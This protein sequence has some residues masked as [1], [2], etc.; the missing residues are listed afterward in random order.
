MH[1]VVN[2]LFALLDW[3][4]LHD[5]RKAVVRTIL[6]L[7]KRYNI[8]I[9]QHVLCT[10]LKY[11]NHVHVF[12]NTVNLYV[13]GANQSII[14][15]KRFYS[16]YNVAV[17]FEIPC[18][19]EQSVTIIN[20]LNKIKMKHSRTRRTTRKTLSVVF[21]LFYS[22]EKK[23]TECLLH[24]THRTCILNEL[25]LIIFFTLSKILNH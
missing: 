24:W 23:R 21:F 15:S 10:D 7:A 6:F 4:Y 20:R 19:Y 18:R 9:R 25:Y 12:F 17:P 22:S 3:T 13:S 14:H 2:L 11:R 8:T 1:L 16:V 5:K